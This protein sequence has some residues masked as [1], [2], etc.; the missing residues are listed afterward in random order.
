MAG[1][2]K[3]SSSIGVCNRWGVTYRFF[4]HA[5]SFE[6]SALNQIIKRCLNSWRL[7]FCGMVGGRIYFS[8]RSLVGRWGFVTWPHR[9]I[10]ARADAPIA[11]QP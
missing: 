8:G 11:V 3:K 1:G 7:D 2:T 10:A 6:S 4:F 9:P 5:Q